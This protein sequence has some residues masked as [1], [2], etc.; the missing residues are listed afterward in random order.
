MEGVGVVSVGAVV[1]DEPVFRPILAA[2]G[3]EGSS[4]LK[5]WKDSSESEK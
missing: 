1:E 2:R 3:G 5:E 4:S